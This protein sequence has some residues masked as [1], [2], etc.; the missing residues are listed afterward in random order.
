[1]FRKNVVIQVLE[2]TE[3][4]PKGVDIVVLSSDA[5]YTQYV[6][7]SGNHDSYVEDFTDKLMSQMESGILKIKGTYRVKL[8]EVYW[9]HKD[10]TYIVPQ[11]KSKNTTTKEVIVVYRIVNKKIK[12][13]DRLSNQS[14]FITMNEFIMNCEYA[15]EL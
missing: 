6:E 3:T 7:V 8:G 1:M 11:T 13:S 2:D 10:N 4:L 15:G 9:N 12:W 14:Y 5:A